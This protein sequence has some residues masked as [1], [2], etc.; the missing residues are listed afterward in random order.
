MFD[1][2]WWVCAIALFFGCLIQS[3]MGFGMAIL[4][5]PIIVLLRPE[6]VPVIL[7]VT[8][9]SL[10][11][12]NVWSLHTFVQWRS[13][14]LAIITRIPGTILG[15]WILTIIATHVLQLT[16]AS[17]VF[18]AVL[19]SAYGK[20]FEPTPTRVGLAGFISGLM[21]TTTSI[22]GP[23]MALIMQH[24]SGNTIRA[25]LSA[26]FTFSCIMSLISY[27]VIGLLNSDLWLASLSFLPVAIFGFLAGKLAR[28]WVDNR[29]R[30]LLLILCTASASVAFIGALAFNH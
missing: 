27:Q 19:I 30:P 28:Q 24:S 17:M 6:W 20:P 22:G 18:L 16:V 9:L 23:P 14:G 13:L 8:A 25:N 11:L 21:G 7:T 5:A 1:L 3:A 2:V 10:S 29:F 4:A 26:Y 15:A 12:I